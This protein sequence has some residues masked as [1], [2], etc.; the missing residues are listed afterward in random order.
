ME[1]VVGVFTNSTL[2]GAAHDRLRSAG[3]PD[4]RISIVYPQSAEQVEKL[5]TTNAEQPG[6]GRAM[7]GVVGGAVGLATGATTILLIPGVGPVL[8]T[9]IFG[10]LLLGAAGAAVGMQM[11]KAAEEYLDEGLPKDEVFVYK[12][13]LRKG[14][15]LV[16]ALVEDE[17]ETARARAAIAESGAEAVDPAREKEA[18]GLGDA[19]QER[20]P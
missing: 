13:A 15:S 6:M 8:A 11:G 3:I 9:A 18:I 19:S 4:D 7:G 10:G 17:D 5:P 16:V 14:R 1:A 2:A 20:Y 12:D